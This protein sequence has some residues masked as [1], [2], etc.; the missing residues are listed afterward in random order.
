MWICQ[1]RL[2]QEGFLLNLNC[3]NSKQTPKGF[4]LSG[5][6]VNSQKE[7][8]K[9]RRPDWLSKKSFQREGGIKWNRAS[10]QKV[11]TQV[12]PHLKI[13]IIQRHRGRRKK[14]FAFQISSILGKEDK[15][16]QTKAGSE[17]AARNECLSMLEK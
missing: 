9:N 15:E 17:T 11:N 1:N 16:A 2:P 6:K 3:Q 7:S 12:K 8:R 14:E 4:S 5:Q 13:Q 10:F